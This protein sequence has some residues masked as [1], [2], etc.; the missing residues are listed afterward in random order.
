[1]G[2]IITTNKE[3]KRR[4]KK[5]EEHYERCYNLN[6][7]GKNINAESTRLAYENKKRYDL[8]NLDLL[9]VL[10]N[11]N[12]NN[13]RI[14]PTLIKIDEFKL[15]YFYECSLSKKNRVKTEDDIYIKLHISTL[16]K[17]KTYMKDFPDEFDRIFNKDYTV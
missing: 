12:I 16:N 13:C 1:M 5:E 3:L 11:C 4:N 17:I 9:P 6:Q 10:L 15:Y 7:L 14:V 2:N 8:S